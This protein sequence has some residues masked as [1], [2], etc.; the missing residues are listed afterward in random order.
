MTKASLLALLKANRTRRRYR[1]QTG[2]V[3]KRSDGFYIRYYRD[4][5]GGR[6]R[7]TQRLCDLNVVDPQKR[8]LLAK[9]HM[10]A[11]NN[12]HH[13]AL[14]SEAP[15]PVLTVGAFWDTIYRPWLQK[16]KRPS[17]LRGYEYVWKLYVKHELAIRPIDSYHTIDASHFLTGLT[18]RLNGKSLSHVRALMSSVFA[19]A[20]NTKGSNGRALI[21]RNPIRDVKVLANVGESK[22]QVAYTPEE[23]IAIINAIQRTEAKLFFA[24]CAVLG[25]RPSEAAA[26]KWENISDG[27]LKVREAAPYGILG[28]LKTKKSKRDLTIT[29]PVTSLLT[30][31]RESLANP[32]EGLM[33]QNGGGQPMNY[34]GFA[35]YHIKPFAE[36]V[37]KRWNGCYS[38]RH[39]A[40]TT[41]YNQEGDVRA[42]YQ[43]LGNS[44]EV[45]MKTYVKPDVEQG[46]KGQ[47]K[48]EDALLK[49]M[50]KPVG[51]QG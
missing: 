7:V 27:V 32:K 36:K 40:A 41:L 51:S 49:A 8:K 21:D 23:T 22:E 5:D 14:R 3:V 1:E 47:A 39:G 34:N 9:S 17:T 45:V 31:Y 43:V 6:T 10:S 19:H 30:T 29:E 42:A 13:T 44:L 46:R 25:M 48:Y 12:L 38:G 24:L 11:I 16:N 35:K 28:P 26:V 4:S 2:S 33:F 20:V 50:K 18:T 37:C 15:A